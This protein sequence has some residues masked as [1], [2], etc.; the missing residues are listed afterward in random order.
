MIV[1]FYCDTSPS[2]QRTIF[3]DTLLGAEASFNFLPLLT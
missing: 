2:L 1:D 3:S